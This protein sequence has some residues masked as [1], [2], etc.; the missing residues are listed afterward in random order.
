MRECVLSSMI[1]GNSPKY[2]TLR[3]RISTHSIGPVK[4]PDDLATGEK[5][6][7]RGLPPFIDADPSHEEMG[8]RVN[9]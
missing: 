7:Q 6:G 5:T 2:D 1:A 8:S 9:R 3:H 4:T